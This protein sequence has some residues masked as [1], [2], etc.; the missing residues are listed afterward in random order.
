MLWHELITIGFSS[1]TWVGMR[2]STCRIDR[3]MSFSLWNFS[4]LNSSL[5]QS[6]KD[7]R[8]LPQNVVLTTFLQ[9]SSLQNGFRLRRPLWGRSE[10]P[11]PALFA[12]SKSLDDRSVDWLLVTITL[13]DNV[14][15]ELHQAAGTAYKTWA[16]GKISCRTL[17]DQKS[18]G[19][20]VGSLEFSGSHFSHVYHLIAYH[21]CTMIHRS[22]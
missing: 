3:Q 1:L 18:P 15:C 10:R 16:A 22:Q 19:I 21:N 8:K 5:V 13:Q 11:V 4:T 20:I 17:F 12:N 14:I 9:A 6:Y 7:P 2:W